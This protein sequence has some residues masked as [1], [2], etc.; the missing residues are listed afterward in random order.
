VVAQVLRQLA[1]D[2][3]VVNMLF[4]RE[5]QH[6]LGEI[7]ADQSARIRGQQRTAESGAAAGIEHI[8]LPRR[9]EARLFEHARHERR[10]A[11][12]QLLELRFKAGGKT[13]ERSLDESI[14]CARR[15][16]STR[17]GRQHVQRNGVARLFV[18]PF[19]EDVHGLVDVAQHTVRERQ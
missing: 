12:R 5:R 16:I 15:H 3:R 13:V 8:E 17:A 6:A 14:R 10:R 9:L 2:Q 11:V 4:L 19:F 1:F 18:E 7:D